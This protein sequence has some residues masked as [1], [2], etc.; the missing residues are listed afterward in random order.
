MGG[1]G[2]GGTHHPKERSHFLLFLYKKCVSLVSQAPK[3]RLRGGGEGEN[4]RLQREGGVTKTNNDEH[5][6]RGVQN[7][8]I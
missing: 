3:T 5:R 7:R 8:K 2:E 6:G 4:E 1:G